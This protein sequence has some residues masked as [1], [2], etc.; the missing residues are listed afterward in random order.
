VAAA[1][2][3]LVMPANHDVA[4]VLTVADFWLSGQTVYVDFIEINPPGSF[5]LYMPFAWLERAVGL[6]ARSSAL[7]NGN[8][9]VLYFG[10]GRAGLGSTPGMIYFMK[11]SLFVQVGH[12]RD[13][14]V[15]RAEITVDVADP[16]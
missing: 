11:D 8:D 9:L 2:L 13:P 4:A 6:P 1:C 14:I 3:R 15:R 5:W 7:S 16:E 10:L 12:R